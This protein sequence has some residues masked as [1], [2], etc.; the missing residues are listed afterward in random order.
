MDTKIVE[1]L[2]G[3]YPSDFKKADV[4][5]DPNY[6]FVNDPSYPATTLLDYDKNIVTVNSFLECE[7]YV[8]GGW[9]YLPTISLESEYHLILFG[10]VTSLIFAQS[11]YKIFRK[12][13]LT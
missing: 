3:K 5:S 2:C 12:S 6:V 7:H 4:L 9:N 10:V 1:Q 11:I 8:S 13:K